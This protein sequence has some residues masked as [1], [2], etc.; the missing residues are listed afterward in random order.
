[1]DTQKLREERDLVVKLQHQCGGAN[2][3]SATYSAET[4][5]ELLALAHDGLRYRLIKLNAIANVHPDDPLRDE[6]FVGEIDRQLAA[7]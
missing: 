4:N 7:L 1:M 5:R 6:T 3:M 2:A